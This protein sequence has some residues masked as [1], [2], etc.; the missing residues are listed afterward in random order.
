VEGNNEVK[1]IEALAESSRHAFSN[2][3]EYKWDNLERV[4]RDWFM[5]KLLPMFLD[6][7]KTNLSNLNGI[8][9][10]Q[11]DKRVRESDLFFPIGANVGQNPV[12]IDQLL[13]FHA[14]M[15]MGSLSWVPNNMEKFLREHKEPLLQ[16]LSKLS[17]FDS[18]LNMKFK[19]RGLRGRIIDRLIEIH[20]T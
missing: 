16:Q 8:L 10:G 17:L 1:K 12:S 9:K 20:E 11:F 7:F 4:T 19:N 14:T 6:S 3:F 13:Q 18:I 5:Q 2:A 15:K